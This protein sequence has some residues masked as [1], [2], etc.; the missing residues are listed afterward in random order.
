MKELMTKS[1]LIILLALVIINGISYFM[2]LPEAQNIADRHYT[3]SYWTLLYFLFGALCILYAIRQSKLKR[4][5]IFKI[6]LSFLIVSF[7]IWA[8]IFYTLTCEICNKGA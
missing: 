5:R 6:A 3:N 4:D 2:I 7:F 8:I 1:N